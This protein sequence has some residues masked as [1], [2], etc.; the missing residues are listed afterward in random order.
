LETKTKTKN[1][2]GDHGL[3]KH[4]H[5]DCDPGGGHGK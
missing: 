3:N 1:P 2:G 4:V 5:S